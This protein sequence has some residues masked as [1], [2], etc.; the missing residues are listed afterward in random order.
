MGVVVRSVE[1]G[2]VT[3]RGA[4]YL[5]LLQCQGVAQGHAHGHAHGIADGRGHGHIQD[6]TQG[7]TQRVLSVA[8]AWASI[9][10]SSQRRFKAIIKYA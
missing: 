7:H 2:R 5:E 4:L 6:H 1:Q 3:L 10:L 9:P 8:D